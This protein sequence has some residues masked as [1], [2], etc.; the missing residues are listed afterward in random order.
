MEKYKEIQG[1]LIEL[2]LKGEFD[3]IAHGC[4]CFCTMGAGIAVSMKNIFHCD[5]SKF[6]P[7]E[8]IEYKGDID[9]LG[10]ISTM[11]F[12]VDITTRELSYGHFSKIFPPKQYLTIVNAYTQYYYGKNHIDGV[13]KPLDYE[14]LTLCMRKIN[15]TFKGKNIGLPQIGCGLAG[16]D[17]TIVSNIIKKELKDCYVT[18][19]I[20]KK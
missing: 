8:A 6:F 10:R 5:N 9:K 19:V 15:H 2:A 11:T 7:L 3:V 13:S 4:N 12:A 18:I 1:D 14:A 17:W 16:G 20:F